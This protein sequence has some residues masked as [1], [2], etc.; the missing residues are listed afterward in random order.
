MFRPGLIQPLHG[1][2]S[3]T[4]LY[5]TFYFVLNPVIG[6]MHSTFP[7][8]VLTTEEIGKAMLLATKRGYPK[9][10]LETKDIRALL[11]RE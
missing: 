1:I 7:N 9:R 8:H 5:R 10:I 11:D 6:L 4:A 2:E 3:K